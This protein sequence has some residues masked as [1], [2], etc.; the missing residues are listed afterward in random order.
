[1]PQERFS[2]SREE[3]Y[4]AVWS[5]PLRDA[6]KQFGVSDVGLSKVCRR[7]DIPRPKRGYWLRRSIGV[8]RA[9]AAAHQPP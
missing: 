4:A 8:G 9:A 5:Q 1:M 3:I 6:C 7:L 2:Y